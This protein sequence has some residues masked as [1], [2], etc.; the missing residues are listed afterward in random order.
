MVV[1][2]QLMIYPEQIR[3]KVFY[4]QSSDVRLANQYRRVSGVSWSVME[5]HGVSWS[6]MLNFGEGYFR[7]SQIQK[8]NEIRRKQAQ[9][10]IPYISEKVVAK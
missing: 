10:R 6:V 7:L 5:C 9:I 4:F 1:G 2:A 8:G 3:S